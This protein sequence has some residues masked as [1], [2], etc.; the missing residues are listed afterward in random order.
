M[1]R[2]IGM[3]LLPLALL[4][5]G[6]SAATP[7]GGEEGGPD[8]GGHPPDTT[9]QTCFLEGTEDLD[10]Q[11]YTMQIRNPE[12]ATTICVHYGGVSYCTRRCEDGSD[13]ADI[14]AGNCSLH[15]R[16]GDP[17]FIGSYCVPSAFDPLP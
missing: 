8:G 16:S 10:P 12:C 6:C 2:A 9:Y 17:D 7:Y 15:I 1:A 14:G 13:C 3:G 4:V 5:A 11:E